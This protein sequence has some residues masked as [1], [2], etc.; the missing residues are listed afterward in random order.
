MCVGLAPAFSRGEA[1]RFSGRSQP[2]SNWP[3]QSLEAPLNV[4]PIQGSCYN[5]YNTVMDPVRSFPKRL[6]T[7]DRALFPKSLC[8]GKDLLM[9]GMSKVER[10]K[11]ILRMIL[12]PLKTSVEV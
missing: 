12:A 4:L 5:K 9:Q 8:T 6:S 1:W 10:R 7:I 11:K 2:I 3:I